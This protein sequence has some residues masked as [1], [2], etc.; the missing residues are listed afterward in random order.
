MTAD[1]GEELFLTRDSFSSDLGEAGGDDAEG[2]RPMSKRRFAPVEDE[3]AGEADNGEVDHVVYLLERLVALD[4]R[5]RLS[6]AIYGI[7]PTSE[8]AR[9]D[10]AKEIAPD[11]AGSRRRSHHDHALGLEKGPK[12]SD[13]RR[14]VTLVDMG[15]IRLGRGER[16]LELDASLV[17]PASDVEPGVREDTKHGAVVGQD[18][19]DEAFDPVT[20]SDVRELLEEAHSDAAPL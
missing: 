19:S 7:G 12:R 17:E 16:K 8:A 3:P 20:R 18:S 1:Q 4:S 11:R 10:V 2:P 15:A 5:D 14:V 9:D 6:L 13:D